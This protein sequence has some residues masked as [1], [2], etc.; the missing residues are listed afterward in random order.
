MAGFKILGIFYF[1]EFFRK[2]WNLINNLL[3]KHEFNNDKILE[4]HVFD[5]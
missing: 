4:K 5:A 2:T 3:E 1:C